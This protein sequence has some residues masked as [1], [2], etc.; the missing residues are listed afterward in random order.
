[1]TSLERSNLQVSAMD[2]FIALDR[3]VD[4]VELL[5]LEGLDCRYLHSQ[6]FDRIPAAKAALAKAKG[7]NH[8]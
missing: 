5:R 6:L 3:L 2:L 8:E 7:I 4:A 1:M